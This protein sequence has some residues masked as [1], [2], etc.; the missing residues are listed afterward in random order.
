[1]SKKYND[2]LACLT[3]SAALCLLAACG[4]GGSGGGGAGLPAIT[5]AAAT[6]E[7][8]P[9]PSTSSPTPPGSEELAAFALLNKERVGCGFGALERNAHLDAAATGHANWQLLNNVASHVQS[10]GTPGFTGVTPRNRAATAGYESTS[11]VGDEFS[12]VIGRSAAT[13]F[14][15]QGIR[16]L[17]SAPYHLLGLVAGYRDV[18]LSVMSSDAAGTTKKLSRVMLQV[19]LGYTATQGGELP[20]AAGTVLSYPCEGTTDTSVG[21]TNETPNP[22]PSRDLVSSPLGQAIYLVGDADKN[23]VISSSLVQETGTGNTVS[24]VAPFVKANDPNSILKSN[25]A[26]ILPDALL[27]PSTQYKVTIVGTN[28]G[29]SFTKAFSFKTGARTPT[30]SAAN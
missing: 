9:T 14:G 22:I 17:L 13:G 24:L 18:G 3:A 4:G 6:T 27:K 1:M 15:A 12:G 10:E 16:T 23:L 26:F 21:F 11:V 7:A 8:A 30:S 20:H 25:E 28:D 5:P 2:V 19:N 29:T